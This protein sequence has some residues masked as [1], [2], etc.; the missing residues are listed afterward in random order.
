MIWTQLEGNQN[1][2]AVICI[3]LI[4]ISLQLLYYYILGVLSYLHGRVGFFSGDDLSGT[5][6]RGCME[7]FE[8]AERN[9]VLKA[10]IN[11][12]QRESFHFRNEEE[13]EH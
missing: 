2:F 13:E 10:L 6:G 9:S 8:L 1:S 5:D 3:Q 12:F 4:A 11:F 7:S